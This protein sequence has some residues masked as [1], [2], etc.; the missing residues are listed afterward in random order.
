MA[1]NVSAG[2]KWTRLEK[3]YI[4]SDWTSDTKIRMVGGQGGDLS[5]PKMILILNLLTKL[6]TVKK[7]ITNRPYLPSKGRAQ[8]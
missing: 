4:H 5:A 8:A 6:K 3:E 2:Q 1:N 7:R